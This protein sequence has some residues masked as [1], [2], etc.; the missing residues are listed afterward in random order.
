[1]TIGPVR[2]R[3]HTV[4]SFIESS[5]KRDHILISSFTYIQK[6]S[7]FTLLLMVYVNDTTKPQERPLSQ[8][9][10]SVAR[11]LDF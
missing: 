11:V 7:F 3:T 4:K 5:G 8:L 2:P 1:M 6:I 9:Q 10:K